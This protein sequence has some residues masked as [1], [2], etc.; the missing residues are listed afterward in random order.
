MKNK[1]VLVPLDLL[2]GSPNVLEFV[3]NLAMESPL[4][5]TLL[6]VVDVNIALVRPSVYDELCA[7]A[8]A[9]LRKLAKLFF[10]TAKAARVA[11]RVGNVSDEIVAEAK[12]GSADMIVL[13]G[14]TSRKRFSL[15]RSRTTRRVLSGAPCATVVLPAPKKAAPFVFQAVPEAEAIYEPCVS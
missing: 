11:V 4:S 5:V 10:G 7:E 3:Q 1:R 13:C 15:F 14:P 2:R 12:A 8:E 6:H 9:A